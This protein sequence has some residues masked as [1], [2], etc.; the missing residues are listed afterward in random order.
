MS[1]ESRVVYA[2]AKNTREE[3]RATLTTW[4]GYRVAD[5]RVWAD[6]ANDEP[7]ATRKGLTIRVEH[8]PELREAVEALLAAVGEDP[9]GVLRKDPDSDEPAE[10]WGV[11]P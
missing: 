7:V 4:Q 8:L 10:G 11:E 2:F 6:N 9:R 1:D 3:V 5:L